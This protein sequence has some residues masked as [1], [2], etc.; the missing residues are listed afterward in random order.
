MNETAGKG[1]GGIVLLYHRPLG[2]GAATVLEHVDAFPKFSR[3]RVWTVN[4]ELGFPS[5]L[6]QLP[7]DVLV[8][9]YSLFGIWPYT[10]GREFERYIT[11]VRAHKIAFFQDEHRY[12]GRRFEFLNTYGVDTVYSLLDPADAD[13]V[14]R[15]RTKVS[16]V[17]YA[18][19]GYVSDDLVA[20]ARTMTVPEEQ[21]TIDI[22]YR[23]RRLAYYMGRGAQEKHEIGRGVL[24]RAAAAGLRVDIDTEE[25]SRLY[26]DSWYRFMANCRAVLGVEAGVSIF[27][28]DDVVRPACEKW[29]AD[30]PAATF[31]ETS[32]AV[33]A[34]FEDNIRYRTISPRHFEAAAFRV[35]QILFDGEYSGALRPMVHYIPLRKDFS[36]WQQVMASFSDAALRRQL[37]ERSYDDLI[38]SDRFSYRTFLRGFDDH[39]ARKNIVPSRRVE[40]DDQVQRQLNRGSWI[41]RGRAAAMWALRQPF[42]GRARAVNFVRRLRR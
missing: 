2:R 16:D 11:G 23:G 14:Y 20:V 41:G 19:P 1:Q 4:T 12:C 22:G 6:P 25:S 32:A 24:E 38:A 7:C 8:F 36:N 13:A 30:H 5:V 3:S 10:I 18:L 34:P 26:G 40:G 39:L 17:Q 35:C 29:L 9:H 28:I 42:P 37:T 27:D 31:E 21:R 33:L 15:P